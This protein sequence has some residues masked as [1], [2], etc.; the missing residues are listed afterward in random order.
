MA[1]RPLKDT[2]SRHEGKGLMKVVVNTHNDKVVG[3]HLVGAEVAETS[4]LL[5]LLLLLLLVS[6]SVACRPL[7]DTLSGHE[8]KGLMKVV[9]NTHNDKVVG[10]HL[11]GAEVA[12]ILQ[13][14]L[15]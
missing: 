5:L 2:L 9:V 6:A 3:I 1:Y 12:E 11:I 10:I 14:C 8:G 13:V 7:K 15:P 4:P